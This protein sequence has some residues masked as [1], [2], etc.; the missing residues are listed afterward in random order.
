MEPLDYWRLCDELTILQ[1]ALLVAGVDPSQHHAV[2]NW[3]VH[4]RPIG[5]EAAKSAITNALRRDAIEGTAIEFTEH[6]SFGNPSGVIPGTI[7]PSLSMVDVES[8]RAWLRGRGLKTGFFFPEAADRPDYLDKSH[9]HYAPKLAAAVNAWLAV[10]STAKSSGRSAKQ[11]LAKWLRE[12]AADF[13]LSDEEGV[14][15]ETGVEEIAKVANWQLT[16]GAPKT[17]GS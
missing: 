17:S 7:D 8:L 15:N 1:A 14:A 4:D 3:N 10:E 16:G 12:N 2:E 13:G 5:F 6:D 11:T 9:P